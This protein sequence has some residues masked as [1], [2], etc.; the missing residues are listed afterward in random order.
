M[1]TEN[2][3]WVLIEN[4]DDEDDTILACARLDVVGK[5]VVVNMFA[6]SLEGRESDQK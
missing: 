4:M 2:M 1:S 5:A 6:Y 3:N